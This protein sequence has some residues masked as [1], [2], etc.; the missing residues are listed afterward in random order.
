MSSIY[1]R[2]KKKILNDSL[3]DTENNLI[4]TRREGG[5]QNESTSIFGGTTGGLKESELSNSYRSFRKLYTNMLT[6]LACQVS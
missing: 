2:F 6:D 4:V 3:I 5:L 1:L